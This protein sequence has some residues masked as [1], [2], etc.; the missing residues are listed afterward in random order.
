[1]L[2]GY[3]VG[4]DEPFLPFDEVGAGGGEAQTSSIYCVSLKN[5]HLWGIKSQP[6]KATDLGELDSKPAKRTRVEWDPGM[7]VENPFA[8]A[9]LTSVTDAP[10]E[11]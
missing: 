2:V 11:A 7:V 3:E 9:R 1:M 6:I 5:G 10:I 8:A 4:P